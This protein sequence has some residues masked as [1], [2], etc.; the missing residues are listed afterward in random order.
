MDI[1]NIALEQLAVDFDVT[2]DELRGR[3]NLVSLRTHD[4][5]KR[6]YEAGERGLQAL[7][8]NGICAFNV[9]DAGLRAA[10]EQRFG[11][12]DAAWLMEVDS[13][14]ALD[15]VIGRYGHRVSA[16]HQYYLPG[17]ARRARCDGAVEWLEADAL[18]AL[19]AEGRFCTALGGD[20][21]RPDELAAVA[22]V[23][24]EIVGM[25][26]A[27]RDCASMW[28]IGVQVAEH[29]RGHGLATALVAQLSDALLARGVVPFYGTS[30]GHVISQRVA[31]GAGFL[32]A[33]GEIYSEADVQRVAD[34]SRDGYGN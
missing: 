16:C 11:D 28:Q 12:F 19:A 31:V 33:W 24:G 27:S 5:R 32:P 3:S 26:A 23:R 17:G 18:A 29:A 9:L 22:R 10:L 21:H 4:A 2:A 15:G 13:L 7:C 14:R 6:R 8:V 30:P 20:P 25:A 1:W 34:L